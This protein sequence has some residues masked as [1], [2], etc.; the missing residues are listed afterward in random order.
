MALCPPRGDI[1]ARTCYQCAVILEH[2]PTVFCWN[3]LRSSHNDLGK[4]QCQLHHEVFPDSQTYLSCGH[5]CPPETFPCS[6]MQVPACASEN[7]LSV[8]HFQVELQGSWGA[9]VLHRIWTPVHHS[10][11]SGPVLSVHWQPGRHHII[12]GLR[13]RRSGDHHGCHPVL[14]PFPPN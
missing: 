8:G 5:V 2:D 7:E 13:L 6:R 10:L 4:S 1:S 11:L 3:G 9:S 12:C 14:Q